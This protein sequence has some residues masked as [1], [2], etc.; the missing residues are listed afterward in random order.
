M[1]PLRRG[2]RKR[3]FSHISREIF[4]EKK[5]TFLSVPS[6]P[7]SAQELSSENKTDSFAENVILFACN[8][9]VFTVEHVRILRCP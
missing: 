5:A 8:R 3:R 6:T 7:L 9:T 2:A 1:M 4:S